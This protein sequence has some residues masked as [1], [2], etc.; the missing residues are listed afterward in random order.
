MSDYDGY[1]GTP[2]RGKSDHERVITSGAWLG[3]AAFTGAMCW[4]SAH[5]PYFAAWLVN[6]A[7]IMGVS[8][9]MARWKQAWYA[10]LCF[11][12]L[13]LACALNALLKAATTWLDNPWSNAT[14]ALAWLA[15]GSWYWLVRSPRRQPPAP[16]Q[17]LHVVHHVVHHVLHH[18]HGATVEWRADTPQVPSTAPWALGRRPVPKAIEPPRL[19]PEDLGAR[20]GQ[21][22]RRLRDRSR[23]QP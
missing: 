1:D 5:V 13:A 23:R 8:Y 21:L 6:T 3:T 4:V 15:V 14:W 22:G 18:G 19:S 9:A 11:W 20:L 7:V 12:G 17:V 16:P 10:W 2:R